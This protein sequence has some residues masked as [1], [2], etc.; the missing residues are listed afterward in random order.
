MSEVEGV[1]ESFMSVMVE[2]ESGT[3]C[4]RYVPPHHV[5][6]VEATEGQHQEDARKSEMRQFVLEELDFTSSLTRIARSFR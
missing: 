6:V 4:Q 5:E 3:S 2:V 1:H